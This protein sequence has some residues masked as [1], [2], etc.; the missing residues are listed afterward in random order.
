M[1][2]VNQVTERYRVI[3]DL[4]DLVDSCADRYGDKPLYIYRDKEDNTEKQF[5]Y[6]MNRDHMVY[7]GTAF[8]KMGIMGKHIAVIGEG[9]PAYMT[10]YYAAVNGGGVIV[11]LDKDLS[12]EELINFI[13]LS[14]VA[15]I[16]YTGMFN[17][18]IAN[19]ADRTP[20]VKYFIPIAAFEE[21]IESPL[22][23][24]YKEVLELGKEAYE[25]GD[26]SFYDHRVE[27]LND[28]CA[29]LFTSGTTGTGKGVMLTHKNL[30]AATISS[31]ASM[32][33]YNSKCTFVSVLPMNHSYEVTCEH[34]AL[35]NIGAT[36][37]FND[38]LK[39]VMRNF[40]KVKPTNLVLVPLFIE[41]MHKKIW[42]EIAKK[43]MTGKVKFGMKLSNFLL[44]FGIDIRRKLFGEILD[45]FGGNLVGIISGG[46]PLEAHLIKDFR[47]FGITILEGYGITEC[48]PLVAV[49]R[50]GKERAHSVG[51]AVEF[52]QVKTDAEDGVST[53]ELLVKG[54]NVMMGY[55]KN[56][57][58]TREVFT[59][60][61]WFKTGDIG[62]IVRDGYIFITG[63]KK[64]L[65]ILSNGKN[66]Y[67]E[68]IESYMSHCD[69]IAE[70]VIVGRKNQ[71]GEIVITALVYPNQ[72]MF[73]GKSKDEIQA[74]VKEQINTVNKKLP[75]Y[76][77]IREVEI[78]D[79]EFEKT[80]SRKIKRYK[81]Q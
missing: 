44:F 52:C 79:T 76:K 80:T 32:D 33:V 67:P 66:I 63:R 3:S 59:E 12:D 14:E 73:E 42:S 30:T 62:H 43:K 29:I 2:N 60:D 72:E 70:G 57:E 45:A 4:R 81:L 11:P 1:A 18:R 10:T 37:F 20:N 47:A 24:P 71:N 22:I 49:N 54:D 15:A 65:I 7:L 21:K 19:F 39:N 55:Y 48:S 6:N 13:N 26:H 25:A 23:R 40:A 58:A 50:Y 75:V 34:L 64:N 28:L 78:R 5:S 9:H 36:T 56:E 17:N 41:T 31:C 77:Q 38:S 68:E 35:A 46:A 61:G 51:T 8:S 74:A 69:T 53:G 16:V 27:D